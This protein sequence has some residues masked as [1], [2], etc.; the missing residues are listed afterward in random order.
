MKIL[1]ER[2]RKTKQSN[3]KPRMYDDIFLEKIRHNFVM[4]IKRS[5]FYLS[6]YNP[7]L[8]SLWIL[9]QWMHSCEVFCFNMLRTNLECTKPALW[10]FW[11][12][13]QQCYCWIAAKALSKS[14]WK[15]CPCTTNN[16][17]EL[18]IQFQH[19]HALLAS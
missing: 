13:L 4:F 16:T 18:L 12:Y 10:S 2:K 1:L 6:F 17:K 15:H 19:K 3:S 14:H 8:F 7:E 5:K 11:Y 9:C